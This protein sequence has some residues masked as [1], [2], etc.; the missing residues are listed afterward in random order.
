MRERVRDKERLEHILKAID[1]LQGEIDRFTYESFCNSPIVFHGYVKC[2][3]IIGEAVYKLSHEFKTLH[4]ELSWKQIE[5]MRHVLVHDYYT[6]NS[7]LIWK[8]IT[9]EVP[10]LKPEIE[11]L[12]QEEKARTI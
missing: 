1:H 11:R 6:L 3:E 7:D 4:P 12:L 10:Q 9:V 5:N 2:I 8:T